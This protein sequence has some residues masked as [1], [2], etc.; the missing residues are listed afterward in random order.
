[1]TVPTAPLKP[2]AAPTLD[3]APSPRVRTE[4]ARRLT[5]SPGGGRAWRAVSTAV[6]AALLVLALLALAGVSVTSWA[7]NR[8]FGEVAAT[9]EL[10]T[11][12]SL[13]LSTRVADVRL[14]AS[15]DVDQVT[16]ALVDPGSTDLPGPEETARARVAVEGSAEGPRVTVSQPGMNR[17]GGLLDEHRDL[18][19]LVPEGHRMAVD[20][21]ADVGGIDAAGEFAS[22]SA[23]S[24]VGDVRLSSVDA[25]GGITVQADVGSVE[26]APVASVP[27]GITV[28]SSLGDVDIA[29]P[30]D[31]EGDVTVTNDV[32]EVSM[33]APGTARRVVRAGSDV[34]TVDVDPAFLTGEGEVIGT[35]SIT[36]SLGDISVSR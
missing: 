4:P 7:I 24:D 10:G 8:G 26:L 22:I 21:R 6:A 25:P 13:T 35:V 16:L 33:T 36:T 1:M 11:P 12:Q 31:A 14:A 28:T 20:L 23:T 2:A 5:P 27:G 3:R 30:L 34:G 19:V 32:G 9:H 15:P 17:F 29:L 18:L